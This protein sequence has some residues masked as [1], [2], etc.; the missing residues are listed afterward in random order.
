MLRMATKNRFALDDVWLLYLE[1]EILKRID[2]LM[3]VPNTFP[4]TPL[5]P[6]ETIPVYESLSLIVR[7]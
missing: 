4:F 5:E 7:V 1:R 6:G 3:P 2:N